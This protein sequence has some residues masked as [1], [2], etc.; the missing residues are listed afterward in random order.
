[1]NS[2]A[3][4]THNIDTATNSHVQPWTP[5]CCSCH[6]WQYFHA[7]HIIVACLT[8]M[9]IGAGIFVSTGARKQGEHHSHVHS[10]PKNYLLLLVT[11]LLLKLL[12]SSFNQLPL[13]ER[14][15]VQ[16]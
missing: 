7:V 6:A 8:G 12:H 4:R 2:T 15:A 10:N 14:T 11:V 9:I 3:C 16:G 13:L 1:M 5:A